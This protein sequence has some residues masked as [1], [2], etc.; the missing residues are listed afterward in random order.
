MHLTWEVRDWNSYIVVRVVFDH[1]YH[2]WLNDVI[3]IEAKI[4]L[5]LLVYFLNFLLFLHFI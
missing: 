4:F 2:H 3:H 1:F 5:I